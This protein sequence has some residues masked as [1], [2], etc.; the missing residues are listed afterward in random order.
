MIQLRVPILLL[1]C[2]LDSL[3]QQKGMMYCREV[4][5]LLKQK[6]LSLSAALVN[7]VVVRGE[8]LE[9]ILQ[10]RNRGTSV[11]SV[12][13]LNPTEI[14]TSSMSRIP[15]KLKTGNTFR[16][17]STADREHPMPDYTYQGCSFQVMQLFPG[18]TLEVVVPVIERSPWQAAG[19]ENAYSMY[20]M[21]ISQDGVGQGRFEMELGPIIIY[22]D[23]QTVLSETIQLSYLRHESESPSAPDPRLV[24]ITVVQIGQKFL[25]MSEPRSE[26]QSDHKI[27][28]RPN[29]IGNSA[30]LDFVL[31]MAGRVRIAEFDELPTLQTDTSTNAETFESLSVQSKG[32]AASLNELWT[33]KMKTRRGGPQ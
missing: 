9:P 3:A 26:S 18:E 6:D 23:Y 33:R 20:S 29:R 7:P 27:T 11:I 4:L 21:N 1:I 12:P 19:G 25:L 13:K 32:G 15:V 2:G 31:A 17:S 24:R 8:V 28:V 10:L 14:I 5:D 30:T 22:G 16:F